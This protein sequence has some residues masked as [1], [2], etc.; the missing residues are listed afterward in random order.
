MGPLPSGARTGSTVPSRSGTVPGPRKKSC[1]RPA[2]RDVPPRALDQEQPGRRRGS[3]VIS[4]CSHESS[5]QPPGVGDD[6]A[7]SQASATRWRAAAITMR[8][9]S[10]AS[11][12]TEPIQLLVDTPAALVIE[13]EVVAPSARYSDTD[14]GA[15]AAMTRWSWTNATS[16]PVNAPAMAILPA[17]SPVTF[18]NSTPRVAFAPPPVEA[19]TGSPVLALG[20]DGR[21]RR[22]GEQDWEHPGRS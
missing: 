15:P 2:A 11:R 14:L 16:P 6:G 19:I 12:E 13:L 20:V 8:A 22:G 10:N 4:H 5:A 17:V 21:P 18:R 3:A 1:R 7:S 9:P